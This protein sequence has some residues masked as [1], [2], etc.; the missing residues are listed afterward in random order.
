M[1]TWTIG[2]LA[3]RTGLSVRTI[4]FYADRG[5]VPESGR[6]EAGYRIFDRE[7]V[8]RL[9]LV[10]TLR[11][12]GIGLDAIRRVLTREAAIA[13]IA[14]THARALEAQIRTLRLH[15]A[16]LA[17]IT[18]H[19]DPEEIELM[20]DLATLNADERR[21]IVQDYLDAVFAGTADDGAVLAK[22][23]M[24]QPELPEDPTPDQLKAWIELAQLLRDPDFRASCRTMAERA[25]AEAEQPGASP[26]LGKAVAEH[27]GAALHGG[28]DP[29]SEAAL[30]I[31]E[32]LAALVGQ[33]SDRTALAEHLDAFTDARVARYWALVGIINGWPPQPDVLPAWEWFITALRAHAPEH[34]KG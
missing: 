26:T 3:A 4:R 17:A 14:P 10:A 23:R 5:V 32:R 11:E 27:A 20:H 28:T 6:T 21:R 34:P 19:T 16:V 24:G 8:A 1:A 2:E 13:E 33:P 31:V 15:H 7:A 25:S 12:L 29:D 30:A 22:M 18:T 9:R